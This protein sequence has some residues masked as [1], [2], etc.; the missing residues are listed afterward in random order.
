MLKELIN[1]LKNKRKQFNG[2]KT[3]TDL[4]RKAQL[5]EKFELSIEKVSNDSFKIQLSDYIPIIN[6]VDR[7]KLIDKYDVLDL[8]CNAVLWNSSKQKVNKGTYYVIRTNDY[9]YNILIN[10][11]K[12][13]VDERTKKEFDE[14]TRK[15][16]I[17]EEKI[18]T[19]NKLKDDYHYFSAKHES[20]GNTYYT[21]Y[22][23]KNRDYSLGI[24]DLSKEDAYDEVKMIICN[25]ENIVG[26][27]N[28]LDVELLKDTILKDLS[29]TVFQKK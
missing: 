21:R 28:V 1:N 24:L 16:N 29:L 26:I 2:C 4:D 9:L 11:N 13:I 3:Y 25:L 10:D 15:E 14:Q 12:V 18:I 23:D 8:L 7:M 22:Y 19:L 20:D 17:T 27:E 5:E 6:F